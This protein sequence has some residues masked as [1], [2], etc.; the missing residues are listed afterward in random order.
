[1]VP[2]LFRIL[3]SGRQLGM[4]LTQL[5]TGIAKDGFYS[6]IDFRGDVIRLFQKNGFIF[7]GEVTVWKDPQLAAV[8]TKNHQLLHGS[9]KRDSAIVR[10]GLADYI[11]ILRKPGINKEPINNEKNGIPF[12]KWCKIASPV[13]M[14]INESDTLQGWRN[15]RENN[16]E[17]HI[18]PT[19][20]QVIENFLLMYSNKGDTVFTPFMGIGSEVYQAVKM[21][22]KAIGFELKESYFDL[23]KKNIQSIVLHKSQKTLF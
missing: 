2:E 4:H 13:W 17:R 21:D 23:A 16:D 18:T 3:K 12:E 1:M 6:V 15:G 10:P 19:Q 11:V 14:D 9:T 22:R 8:R 7:H 20:L 5:T